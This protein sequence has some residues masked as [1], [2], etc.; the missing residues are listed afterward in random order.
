[1]NKDKDI[2]KFY[3]I[4][5]ITVNLIFALC[6]VCCANDI[7]IKTIAY[8]GSSQ[9]MAGQIAIASV[10]KTRMIQRH[11]TSTAVCKAPYQF[12]CWNPKTGAPTQRRKLTPIEMEVARQAWNQ[13]RPRKYNHYCR[14]DVKPYW[15]KSAKSSERIGDHVFYEL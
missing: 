3:L 14:W 11:Q 6:V 5:S 12:S 2:L 9:S 15:I 13:A 1:M 7:A 10:I 8:E 4:A